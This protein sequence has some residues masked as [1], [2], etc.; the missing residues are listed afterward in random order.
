MSENLTANHYTIIVSGH[1]DHQWQD[2]F[3][4]M[5]VFL[6]PE[7]LTRISGTVDDQS[8]LFGMISRI[9]DMKLPL[10]LVKRGDFEVNINNDRRRRDEE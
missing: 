9:R 3:P 5:T 1:I 4:G 7:G 6:L 2:W 10:L 8:A